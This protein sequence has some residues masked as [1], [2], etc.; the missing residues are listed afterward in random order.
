[1]RDRNVLPQRLQGKVWEEEGG[2]GP[3]FGFT[4]ITSSLLGNRKLKQTAMGTKMSPNKRFNEQQNIFMAIHEL[5]DNS[6]YI[7]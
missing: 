5:S 7:L 2:V 1:M 3:G 4:K 6:W